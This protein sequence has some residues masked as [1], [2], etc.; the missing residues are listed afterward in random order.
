MPLVLKQRA[1]WSSEAFVLI[2]SS[3]YRQQSICAA[4][5][6]LNEGLLQF[7]SVRFGSG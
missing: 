4:I 7:S 5:L 1:Y 2:P 6:S 3:I